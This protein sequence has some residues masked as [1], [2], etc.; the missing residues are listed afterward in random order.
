MILDRYDEKTY[1][2]P[3]WQGDT[4]YNE[5][6]LF[7]NGRRRARLLFPIDEIISVRSFD[8]QTEYKEGEDF[9]VEDGELV[10]SDKTGI[11]VWEIDPLT[12][13]PNCHVFPAREEGLFLYDTCGIKMREMTV[14]V[15]YKHSK[16]FSDGYS[17]KG[18][19]S[20]R[21]KIPQ[22]FEKLER[23][24]QLNIMLNGDSNYTS[25]GCSGGYAEERFFDRTDTGSFYTVGLNVPP[26]SPP[27]FDMFIS[28]L[29]K[30]YPK[31]EI[32][33]DNISMGGVDARWASEHLSAR[34]KLAKHRPDIIF[35][36][37]GVND[38][39]G[40]ATP[41]TY[42]KHNIE[43]AEKIRS[44]ENGNP[45]TVCVFVSPHICNTDAK[46]YPT[47][48]FLEYEKMLEEICGEL[49]NCVPIR[50]TSFSYD[51]AKC[52]KPLDRL[53]NNINHMMDFSGRMFAQIFIESMR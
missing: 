42:K 10:L 45:D 47:E 2:L 48:V 16:T 39:C 29:R 44:D 26:Y 30:M 41:E 36:G 5:G 33:V 4:V 40:G 38:L 34:L 18:V 50:L 32:N 27:W 8:L 3:V 19:P 12:K 20:L 28:V 11:P 6:V 22:I 9:F 23:G 46:C 21:E 49:E 37:Y 52:K 17:G 43:I 53:E 1:T 25:W 13:T 7:Y 24:E 15:T 35:V 14:C 31:A 51:I